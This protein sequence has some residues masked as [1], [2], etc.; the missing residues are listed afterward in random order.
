MADV[1]GDDANPADWLRAATAG[2]VAQELEGIYARCAEAIAARGPAC[3]A[4]GRCCNFEAAGHL[5]YVTGLEAAY[6]VARLDAA[7]WMGAPGKPETTEITIGGGARVQGGGAGADSAGGLA[8][9]VSPAAAGRVLAA[10]GSGCVFQKAN[11]CGA[12]TIKPLG[13]R[14]YFCDRSAQ[15]WQ[16]DVHEMLITDLRRLHERHGIEYRY[17]EWRSMLRQVLTHVAAG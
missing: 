13:C 8:V 5:L 12:H 3:W 7:A 11:L 15:D 2:V 4:S 1:T 16:Q 10:I 14:I 9:G 17:G 6:T